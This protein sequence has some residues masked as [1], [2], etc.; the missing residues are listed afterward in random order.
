VLIEFNT[1]EKPFPHLMDVD[2]RAIRTARYKYIHW[3]K[4][5]GQE[6]LYDLQ[7][8]PL[9]RRNLA[10]DP[11]LAPVKASLKAELGNLVLEAMGLQS[12]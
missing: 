6:E 7:S 12:R 2:Y 8:D 3:I 9:E 4:Y 11:A 5:P 1:N 10:A